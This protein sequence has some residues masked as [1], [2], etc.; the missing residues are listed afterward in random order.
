MESLIGRSKAWK[1]LCKV[2]TGMP[3]EDRGKYWAQNIT[4]VKDDRFKKSQ[5]SF[6]DKVLRR[7]I[8]VIE[9]VMTVTQHIHLTII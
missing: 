2:Q 6:V 3:E 7:R 1:R 5:M 8:I 4:G 9:A